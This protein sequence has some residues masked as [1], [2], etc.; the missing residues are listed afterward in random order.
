MGGYL[1][2]LSGSDPVEIK[3]R[4]RRGSSVPLEVLDSPGASAEVPIRMAHEPAQHIRMTRE[5]VQYVTPPTVIGH[6]A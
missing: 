6:L 5:P 2:A 4:P 3:D 1:I